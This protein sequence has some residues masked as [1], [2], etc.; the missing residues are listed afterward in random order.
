MIVVDYRLNFFKYL[1]PRIFTD[2]KITEFDFPR[3]VNTYTQKK[4][5]IVF[6]G[7]RVT[8]FSIPPQYSI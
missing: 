4:K 7:G 3:L 8:L 2:F 5:K 1:G 6:E